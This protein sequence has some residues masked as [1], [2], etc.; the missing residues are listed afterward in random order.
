MTRDIAKSVAKNT[1]VMMVSQL[2]TWLST[3]VLM[4]FL[5][6]Y[7]GSEDFGRLYLAMSVTMIAQVVVNFGGLYSIT[8]EAS[9]APENTPDLIVNSIG[10]RILFWAISIVTLVVFSH[11]VGYSGK[12]LAIIIILGV[13]NLWWGATVVLSSCFRGFEMMQYPA[14]GAIVERVFVAVVGVAALLLGA[15][16]LVIAVTMAISMLLNFLVCVWFLPRIVTY[17]PRFDWHAS[18][19]LIKTSVPYFLSSIFS[20]LY[21]RVDAILMSLMTPA[22]VVGSYG[23][24][25]RFFDTL[26][27]LP[28]IFS[29]AVFPVLSRLWI[30]KEEGLIRTTQKSLD[31]IA[32]AAFPIS[33]SIFV[34][35][36]QIIQFFFGLKEYS[37]SVVVLQILSV[38]LVLVYIDFILVNALLASDKQRRWS[39]VTVFALPLNVFLNY[40]L[41]PHTQAHL[42]NGGIGAAIAT[43]VT[44]L[45]IMI[46]AVVVLPKGILQASRLTGP[47][48]AIAGTVLMLGSVLLLRHWGVPWIIEA[49]IGMVVYCTSVLFMKVLNSSELLFIRDFLSFRN[50]MSTFVTSREAELGKTQQ[51]TI[52]TSVP[53]P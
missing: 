48:K 4:L 15:N 49:L 2:I 22:A 27:F 28:V 40:Y 41:I 52:F 12:S 42:G 3:F 11:L 34:F 47:L 20:M 33:A 25:Y 43:F 9:R 50:L 44:E 17:I 45:F 26:M 31:F 10:I 46:S 19:G 1:T 30:E 6:R 8:K 51:N 7:L 21:F 14:L 36:E 35:A 24:A 16:S 29:I 38:T 18:L 37:S 32:L 23:A 53:S 39:V 13:S 5:P